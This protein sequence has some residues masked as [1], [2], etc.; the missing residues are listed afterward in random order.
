MQVID[1][2]GHQQEVTRKLL[3]QPCQRLMCGVRVDTPVQKIVATQVVKPVHQ[4][5]IDGKASRGRY[6]FDPVVFPQTVVITKG[7]DTRFGR[8][9]GTG[10]YDDGLNGR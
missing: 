10:Q 6:I 7:P 4:H 9:A 1:I 3:L 8:Y 5:K 2:L